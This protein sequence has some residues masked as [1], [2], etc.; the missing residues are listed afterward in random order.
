[1]YIHVHTYRHISHNQGKAFAVEVFDGRR[2]L[3]S[4]IGEPHQ[5]RLLDV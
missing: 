5:T 1:M 2:C 4:R 3:V